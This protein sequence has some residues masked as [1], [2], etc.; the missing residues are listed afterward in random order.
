[1]EDLVT[2]IEEGVKIVNQNDIRQKNF[3]N[4]SLCKDWNKSFQYV[5]NNLVIMD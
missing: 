4:N 2:G 1:V 3:T 5:L